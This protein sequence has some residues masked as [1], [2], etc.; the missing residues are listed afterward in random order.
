[1]PG[2][3][4]LSQDGAGD[5]SE[6]GRGARSRGQACHFPMKKRPET[7]KTCP[8]SDLAEGKSTNLIQKQNVT[9][10]L[11]WYGSQNK[12]YDRVT[13]MLLFGFW[14]P[15]DLCQVQ[16]KR[17]ALD[18]RTTKDRSHYRYISY[19]ICNIIVLY[20]YM[21]LWFQREKIISTASVVNMVNQTISPIWLMNGSIK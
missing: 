6:K 7:E 2:N 10:N 4:S 20:T 18:T 5:V 3:A 21:T 12:A 15:F 1:M 14:Q 8:W 16:R 13:G 9:G 19:H 11:I 17:N